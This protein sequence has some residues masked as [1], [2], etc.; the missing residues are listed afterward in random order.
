MKTS[1][2]E[3]FNSFHFDCCGNARKRPRVHVVLLIP[4]IHKDQLANILVI[5]LCSQYAKLHFYPS[6]K[7]N[8]KHDK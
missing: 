6:P 5:I 2:D 8:Q 3:N 4:T 7:S 1:S